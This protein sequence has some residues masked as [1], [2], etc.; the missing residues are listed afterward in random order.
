[1]SYMYISSLHYYTASECY[2][3]HIKISSLR[4]VTGLGWKVNHLSSTP[5]LYLA[6]WTARGRESCL[7]VR[8]DMIAWSSNVLR[9]ERVRM[10]YLT[11]LSSFACLCAVYIYAHKW[12]YKRFID[13]VSALHTLKPG[14]RIVV[15][16]FN[17]WSVEVLCSWCCMYCKYWLLNVQVCC[18]ESARRGMEWLLTCDSAITAVLKGLFSLCSYVSRQ[19]H[20]VEKGAIYS[21][22]SS[23][24]TVR[25]ISPINIHGMS[26]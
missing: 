7:A 20:S 9:G 5:Q 12:I 16:L 4:R 25:A 10:L 21:M 17:S 14:L 23:F 6:S 22:Q 8:S 13:H 3:M 24:S 11:H 15:F 18:A 1:M 26:W 19:P 2:T